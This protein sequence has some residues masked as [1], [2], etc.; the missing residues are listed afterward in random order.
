[1]KQA[2]NEDRISELWRVERVAAEADV[3]AGCIWTWVDNGT[4][5]PPI[6]FG[7]R[8]KRWPA[9]VVGRHIRGLQDKAG[10]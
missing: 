2:E 8:T 6:D 1:M 10:G 5:P 9:E 3:S 7:P 4:F